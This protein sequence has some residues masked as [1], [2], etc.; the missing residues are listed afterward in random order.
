MTRG[1]SDYG[2]SDQQYKKV[3]RLLIVSCKHTYEIIILFWF[4][5]SEAIQLMRKHFHFNN[6]AIFVNFLRF[7]SPQMERLQNTNTNL[8]ILASVCVSVVRYMKNL[9]VYN[10]THA[11]WVLIA[12][13]TFGCCV[14]Y[15]WALSVYEDVYKHT[16]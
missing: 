14:C 16:R 7:N 8:F 10:L 12:I 3:I 11:W 4:L 5:G 2:S 1:K 15:L 6:F 9:Y 13:S